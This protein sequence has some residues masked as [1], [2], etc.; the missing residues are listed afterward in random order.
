MLG[1][2]SK[3]KSSD[4]KVMNDSDE[5]CFEISSG[6]YSF[7]NNLSLTSIVLLPGRVGLPVGTLPLS[8]GGK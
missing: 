6:V 3:K 8:K 2:L 7:F 1:K 5:N 4:N